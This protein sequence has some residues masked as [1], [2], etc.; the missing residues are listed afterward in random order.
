MGDL[1]ALSLIR[2]RAVQVIEAAQRDPGNEIADVVA[3]V[4]AD[5]ALIQSPTVSAFQRTHSQAQAYELQVLAALQK[6]G[7]QVEPYLGDA[8][9]SIDMV[10]TTSSGPSWYRRQVSKPNSPSLGRRSA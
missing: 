3:Q 10:V 5:V 1:Y 4:V 6:A 2:R 7:L 9:G 8:Q